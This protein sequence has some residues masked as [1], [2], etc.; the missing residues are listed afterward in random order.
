M[1]VCMY[2]CM[3][4]YIYIHIYIYIYIYYKKEP[5]TLFSLLYKA[6]YSRF[7][8]P[9]LEDPLERISPHEALAHPWLQVGEPRCS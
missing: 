7:E 5:Q 1:Y 9:A 4:V 2:V 6:P 8:D 3:Y